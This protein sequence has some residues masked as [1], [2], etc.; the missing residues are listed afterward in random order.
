[1]DWLFSRIE[2]DDD[3]NLK[4]VERHQINE[5]GNKHGYATN[6]DWRTHAHIV[7]DKNDKIIYQRDNETDPD[8]HKWNS[9]YK[10]YIWEYLSK[11]SFGE[12]QKIEAFS[13]NKYIKKSARYYMNKF[14][15]NFLNANYA[16]E[17]TRNL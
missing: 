8:K 5:K 13:D 2:K 6:D 11:C 3:G 15:P 14:N 10:G 7:R 1:M 4:E 17:K 16:L 12:L 9:R